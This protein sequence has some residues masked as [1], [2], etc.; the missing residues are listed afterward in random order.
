MMPLPRPAVDRVTPSR[1]SHRRWFEVRRW[2]QTALFMGLV[3]LA[4]ALPQRVWA[5]A[6]APPPYAWFYWQSEPSLSV[7]PQGLQFIGCESAACQ[8]PAW[9]GEYGRCSESGCFS[10]GSATLEPVADVRCAGNRCLVAL[11]AF[12]NEPRQ[13]FFQL[14][15]QFPDRVRG[16]EPIQVDPD[17]NFLMGDWRVAIAETSLEVERSNRPLWRDRYAL[18][19]QRAGL[20]LALELTVA[21]L[22]LGWRRANRAVFTRTL[23]TVF[24]LHFVTLPVVWF[25]F[26][27]LQPFQYTPMRIMGAISLAVAIAYGLIVWRFS[28]MSSAKLAVG[29]LVGLPLVLGIGFLGAAI[30]GYGDYLPSTT[31]G[32]PFFIVLIGA[33][34]FAFGY[35]ALLIHRLS[36]GQLS[37]AQASLLSLLTNTASLS[38]GVVMLLPN[39]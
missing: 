15:A 31:Q 26:P 27:A 2:L 20:T 4:I 25:F 22:Y 35:E 16:S 37:L 6:P 36:L 30:T 13:A 11:D 9:L 18:F 21:A 19:T 8:Q 14:I 5:N 10:I 1:Y 28:T 33:E 39:A 32:L 23:L 7:P 12:R 24:V 17:L 3:C 29:S 38:V 34:L